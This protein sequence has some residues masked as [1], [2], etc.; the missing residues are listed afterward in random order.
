MQT[1]HISFQKPKTNTSS[2]E[3]SK[4]RAIIISNLYVIVDKSP[5]LQCLD[6]GRVR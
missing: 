3:K 2:I 4:K 1:M 6:F 5:N